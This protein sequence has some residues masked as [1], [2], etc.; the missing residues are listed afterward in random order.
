MI[1]LPPLETCE[2][3]KCRCA[4]AEELAR[5]HDRTGDPRYLADAIAVHERQ[6]VCRRPAQERAA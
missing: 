4:A 1:Q 3:H 5:I 6:V 2:H